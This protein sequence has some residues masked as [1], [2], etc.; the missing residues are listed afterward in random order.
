MPLL[1][2]GAGELAIR[3]VTGIV[4]H[5]VPT[6]IWEAKRSPP[7]KPSIL[8]AR[9]EHDRD[10][11]VRIIEA[12][13][14]IGINCSEHIHLN[15]TPADVWGKDVRRALSSS[16]EF[17]GIVFLPSSFGPD[18]ASELRRISR[19]NQSLII[20]TT[21]TSRSTRPELNFYQFASLAATEG[22]SQNRDAVELSRALMIA[23]MHRVR[24]R[25][26][27]SSIGINLAAVVTILLLCVSFVGGYL[28]AQGQAG[29]ALSDTGAFNA[30][31]LT[32]FGSHAKILKSQ[33]GMSAEC[34]ECSV[35]LGTGESITLH[36]VEFIDAL[37]EFPHP[38]GAVCPDREKFPGRKD[39]SLVERSRGYMKP[40]EVS[41]DWKDFWKDFEDK[42][43]DIQYPP[44]QPS[45]SAV[46]FAS[47]VVVGQRLNEL[48]IKSRTAR[49]HEIEKRLRPLS[50]ASIGG[51]SQERGVLIVTDGDVVKR[52]ADELFL[53]N[54]VSR[55]PKRR[56]CGLPPERPSKLPN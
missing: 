22:E 16:G 3:L 36:D 15:G 28:L 41:G 12:A 7:D 38:I 5:V 20:V 53:V 42:A 45:Q 10:L 34:D 2:S 39:S 30:V 25:Q 23:S 19:E 6:I 31:M 32:P 44:N 17:R 46:R 4:K 24:L 11:G 35:R 8:L 43:L 47:I 49:A 52:G 40:N 27:V 48:E 50:V 56:V 9:F 18:L 51:T 54:N 33:D 29:R 55:S 37:V 26:W 14:K 13:N 1:E 21:G